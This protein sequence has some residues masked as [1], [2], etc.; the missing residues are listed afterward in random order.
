MNNWV[1]EA[2]KIAQEAR[3]RSYSPYSKFKVGAA[4][5]TQM[6]EI[7]PGCNVENASFGGTVCAER[8]AVFHMISKV[9][10]R[11]LKGLVL[12]TEPLAV[13]CGFCLQVLSEFAPPNF[14]IHMFDPN[15]LHHVKK[16]ADL[17][18]NRFNPASLPK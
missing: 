7:Y 8:N 15:G 6:D 18:P 9:G 11:P 17:L 5:V 4:L 2:L 14:E 10:I 13:P 12:I 16:L 3:D 1:N